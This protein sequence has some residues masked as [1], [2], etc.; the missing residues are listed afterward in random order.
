MTHYSNG[1][2]KKILHRRLNKPLRLL[3]WYNLDYS[4]TEVNPIDIGHVSVHQVQCV[5]ET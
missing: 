3:V 4:A 1:S 5:V 2:S